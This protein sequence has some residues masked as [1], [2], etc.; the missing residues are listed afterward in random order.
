MCPTPHQLS[1]CLLCCCTCR[2]IPVRKYGTR[3]GLP[4][5]TTLLSVHATFSDPGRPLESHLLRSHDSATNPVS[6]GFHD[7][8]PACGTP[9][10]FKFAFARL[11]ML[12][13]SRIPYGL[14][15]SLFT[16]H[17]TVTSF[18]AKLGTGGRLT[19]TR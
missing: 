2:P 18:G 15:N 3:K 17:L 16:L 14:Y 5:S 10:A 19:L 8:D 6:I 12:Q 4:S 9:S 13:E 11:N 7:V 1:A